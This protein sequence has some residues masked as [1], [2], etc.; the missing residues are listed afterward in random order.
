MGACRIAGVHATAISTTPGSRLAVVS[1]VNQA[2]AEKIAA[3]Y[4]AEARATDA[5][6]NDSA[7]NAVLIAT[8]TDT[9]YRRARPADFRVAACAMASAA[10]DGADG[11]RSAATAR[12]A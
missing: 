10:T 5:I 3:Q 11:Y 12:H 8:S 1:D 6:L 4:G 9:H 7:N 2:A